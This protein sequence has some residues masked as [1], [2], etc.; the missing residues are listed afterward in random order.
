MKKRLER[1]IKMI[2]EGS[3]HFQEDSESWMDEEDIRAYVTDLP[4]DLETESPGLER[5]ARVASSVEEQ[6]AQLA[7]R[8]RLAEFGTGKTRESASKDRPS[9]SPSRL[10][11]KLSL[12]EKAK[13]KADTEE[14]AAN[15]GSDD[16][17]PPAKKKAKAKD[18]LVCRLCNKLF[19]SQLGLTY[20]VTNLVCQRSSGGKSSRVSPL[21]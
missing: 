4:D 6:A 20:H 19:T 11:L 10:K 16:D 7:Q 9:V 2:E 21:C 13:R 17:G 15:C 14:E 1:E 5:T 12:E 18:E 3:F 8:Q